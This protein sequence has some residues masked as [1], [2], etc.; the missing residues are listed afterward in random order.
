MHF[1]LFMYSNLFV[2]L[3]ICRLPPSLEELILKEE[4]HILDDSVDTEGDLNEDK[5]KSHRSS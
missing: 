2:C 5:V 1:I 4:P 3:F